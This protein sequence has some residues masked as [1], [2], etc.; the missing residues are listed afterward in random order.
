MLL[1]SKE[2]ALKYAGNK[3]YLLHFQPWQQSIRSGRQRGK[4]TY[5]III[6]GIKAVLLFPMVSN[7]SW[8]LGDQIAIM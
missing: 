4:A 2:L 3:K 7:P 6:L 1:S 5:V 8:M